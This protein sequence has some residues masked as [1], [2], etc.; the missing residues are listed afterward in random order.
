MIRA[1]IVLWLAMAC[2]GIGNIFLRKGMQVVGPLENYRPLA[3]A[4]Y[5]FKSAGN[6]YV[7]LGV[8]VSIAYFF[9]WLVVLSWANVSWALPMN[10][11]EYVFVALMAVFFLKE[12]ID[13]SR[14]IGI[15]LISVGILFLVRSW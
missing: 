13:V 10:A 8:I 12:K 11:I 3:L 4:Q 7:I 1:L 6:L 14:W 5:F 9:L 2:A 15:G